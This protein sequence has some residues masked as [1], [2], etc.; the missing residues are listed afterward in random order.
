[1]RQRYTAQAV[2]VRSAARSAAIRVRLAK[3]RVVYYRRVMLPLR[4]QILNETQRQFNAMQ[5]GAFELLRAKQEQVEAA[6]QYVQALND[7]GQA[8]GRLRLIRGGVTPGG[9]GG[10]NGGAGGSQPEQ[11]M[12][13]SD[14]R[15]G[16]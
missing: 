12:S 13:R 5:V 3:D 4:Q 16:H 14:D 8:D 6:G 10:A 15:G 9:G 1:M 7:Y 11:Q 2:E